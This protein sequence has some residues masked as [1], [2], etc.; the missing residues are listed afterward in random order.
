MAAFCVHSLHDSDALLVCLSIY[1]PLTRVAG[2]V[3]VSA[4]R[5][6]G[7][8]PLA[9]EWAFFIFGRAIFEN[10]VKRKKGKREKL[11]DKEPVFSKH[12]LQVEPA[13]EAGH[14]NGK[15]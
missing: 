3:S 9:T 13:P 15:R 1:G 4:R 7:F 6:K 2:G 12:G 8:G 14:Y 11:P 10:R 5:I